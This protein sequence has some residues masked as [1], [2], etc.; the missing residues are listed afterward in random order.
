MKS[1]HI[2][3]TFT[4]DC[5]LSLLDCIQRFVE[6]EQIVFLAVNGSLRGIDVFC[7]ARRREIPSS[8][9]NRPSLPATDGKHQPI[10]KQ[11]IG[12]VVLAEQTALSQQIITVMSLAEE[13]VEPGCIGRCIAQVELLPHSLIYPTLLQIITPLLSNWR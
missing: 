4:E 12:G 2:K 6:A 9:G 7:F 10:A 8:E 5:F 11:W 13:I 3:V 1:H